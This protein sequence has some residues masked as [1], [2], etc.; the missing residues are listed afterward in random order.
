MTELLSP[1]VSHTIETRLPAGVAEHLGLYVYLYVDPRT[2]SPFYVGKGKG[3][4][5]LAHLSDRQDS[6]KTQILRQLDDLGL[7]PRLEI[8]SHGIRD[9][10][11]ALRVEAAAID[12]L[13]L[14]GLTNQC[15]GWKSLELGRMTLS[16]LK[17]YYAAAPV[18]VTDP[19]VLIRINKFF[20]HNMSAEELYEVT[21]G[22]WRTGPRRE[23]AVYALALFQGVVREVYEIQSWHPALT[24]TYQTRSFDPATA[25]GRWEFQGVLA[26]A[27]VR[28]RYHGKSV[29]QYFR[30]GLQNPICYINIR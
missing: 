25:K 2:N 7:Q 24:T 22:I 18:E 8:L 11:T 9:E 23:H 27:V 6:E 21:R 16:E 26:P 30:Q 3:D 20:R 28:D 5:V 4:R 17:G 15:R 12:L 10:E 14:G 1:P 13:G 19:C 29:R